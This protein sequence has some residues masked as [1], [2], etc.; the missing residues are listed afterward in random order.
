MAWT[1]ITLQGKTHKIKIQA[2]A[3]MITC[4]DWV[5]NAPLVAIYKVISVVDRFVRLK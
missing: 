2:Q 5:T 1:I 4:A 3:E